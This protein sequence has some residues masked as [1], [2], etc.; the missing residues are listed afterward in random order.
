VLPFTRIVS[1]PLTV[2]ETDPVGVTAEIVPA[3]VT[4]EIDPAGVV[5]A[6]CAVVKAWLSEPPVAPSAVELPPK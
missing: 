4:A 1:L 2:P 6:S 3:G 5:T